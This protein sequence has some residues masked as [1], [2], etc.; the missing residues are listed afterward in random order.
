MEWKVTKVRE[1]TEYDAD[2]GFYRVKIAEFTVDGAPHTIKVSMSDFDNG[3]IPE[4]VKREAEKIL[5]ALSAGGSG[6]T[7]R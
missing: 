5:A 1:A 3:K 2:R 6:K 7:G 4:I